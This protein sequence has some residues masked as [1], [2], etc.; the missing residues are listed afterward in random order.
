MKPSTISPTA[1]TKYYCAAGAI[2]LI[3]LAAAAVIL[4]VGFVAIL[5]GNSAKAVAKKYGIPKV[6]D[7][8]EEMLADEEIQ[9]IDICTWNNGHAPSAIAAAKAGMVLLH[10]SSRHNN[11]AVHCFHRFHRFIKSVLSPGCATVRLFLLCTCG[12]RTA[13]AEE[14]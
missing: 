13:P 8:I 6:Y 12:N 1:K 11:T 3:A 9:A 4:I 10:N 2:L 7:T 5:S 14:I